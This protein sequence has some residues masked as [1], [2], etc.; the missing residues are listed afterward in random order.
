MILAP[1]SSP[2]WVHKR[3]LLWNEVEKSET[4]KNSQLAR[5]IN[6]ALPKE[7]T[8]DQQ[9]ELIKHYIHTQFVDKGMIADIAVHRD[10]LENPHAH[11]MLT[12]REIS[13]EGFGKKIGIGTIENY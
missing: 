2:E 1:S 3:N 13:E 10:N 7:L 8:K 5:E 9:T 4:R 12:T 11:V 6:I